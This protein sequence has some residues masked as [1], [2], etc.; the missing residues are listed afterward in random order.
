MAGKPVVF[1]P[2]AAAEYEAAFDWYF[3]RSELAASK[4]AAEL[5]VAVDMIAEGPDRWPIYTH[6]T[7][8]FVLKRFPFIVV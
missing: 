5:N 2:Q 1:H 7:R 6:G 8:K 4:F 3:Q